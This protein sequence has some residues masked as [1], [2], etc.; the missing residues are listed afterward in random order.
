[1]DADADVEVIA[2]LSS[3]G[4]L[5][6]SS[7]HQ[8]DQVLHTSKT[9]WGGIYLPTMTSPRLELSEEMPVFDI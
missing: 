8:L 3:N 6:Q 9:L 7:I 4:G 5:S 2:E 1:M